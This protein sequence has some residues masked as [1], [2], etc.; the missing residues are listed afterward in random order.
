MTKIAIIAK[1]PTRTLYT[2]AG[3]SHVIAVNAPVAGM[4]WFCFGD[5]E[6][7]WSNTPP[8]SP[9]F[10]N[11]NAARRLKKS[12]IE[13]PA[14]SLVWERLFEKPWGPT[15]PAGWTVFS[16]TAALALARHLGGGAVECFGVID[17]APMP[18]ELAALAAGTSCRWVAE[19]RIW[20]AMVAWLAATDVT[21]ACR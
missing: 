6:T 17:A 21:V 5:A 3:H 10:T 20:N 11:E 1:G 8:A 15:L 14:G 9:W 13:L 16:A 2:P 12:G 4:D 19:R 18:G 7:I